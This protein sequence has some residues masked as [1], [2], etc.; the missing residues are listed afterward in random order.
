[1]PKRGAAEEL[2]KYEKEHIY[3]AVAVALV[4]NRLRAASFAGGDPK[5]GGG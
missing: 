3:F 4:D 5:R 1:L 2:D